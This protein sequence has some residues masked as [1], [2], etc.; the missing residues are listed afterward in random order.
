M[1]TSPHLSEPAGTAMSA[2]PATRR[3]LL[4]RLERLGNRLPNPI[5]LFALLAVVVLI[6]SA[7]CAALGVEVRHPRDGSVIAA[8]NLIS[9]DGVQRIFTQAVKNFMGFAPLGMVLA[10]MIGIGVAE[11]SGLIGVLLRATVMGVP[12]RWLTP[13]IVFVGVMGNLAADAG[14]VILPPLAA[15]L[16]AASGRHPLAGL[17]AGFAGVS[18]GFSANLLPSSLDVLL[19]GLTQEAVD[20]SRLLD[21]YRVQVLGNAW[22]LMASTPVL[23]VAGTWVTHRF[24]EPRLGPWTGGGADLEPLTSA[25]R[26]G[27][28]A[29]GIA[30]LA[31][32][33]AIALL[34]VPAGAPLR[35]DEHDLLRSLAPF[36]DSMVLIVLLAFLVPGIAYGIAA[37]T[38]TSDDDVAT[39]T[40]DTMASMGSYIVVA[41]VAAQ[42]LGWFSWSN[43]APIVAIAGARGLESAGL[44]GAPLLV[45]FVLFCATINLLLTSASANWSITAPVFVPMFVLLGFSPE[46]TQAAFRV[47]DSA[48]NIVS[49]LLPYLPF[50]LTCV[51]R[52]APGAGLGTFLTLM[53]PYSLVFL[54]V[55]TALLLMFYGLGWP[56]GP[57]VDILLR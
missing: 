20:G 55:W 13:T 5:T 36:F 34:T 10:A 42:F 28:R 44:G 21:G 16:F 30:A 2:E 22:F 51:R 56:I 4:D 43:L 47:G 19:A 32:I 7:V 24:V 57:G 52:Y 38:I 35:A 54:A 45:A 40:S 14:L 1:D 37:R 39:M 18:G 48:T 49:P 15:M 46:G 33:V 25:E 27:L 41:F 3:S 12:A 53:L 8:V 9:R 11:R 26:R 29:A 17:A 50:L 31:T 23:V 6:A